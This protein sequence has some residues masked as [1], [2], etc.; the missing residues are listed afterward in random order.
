MW[1]MRP[2]S[3]SRA[4]A[5]TAR[6]SR[7]VGPGPGDAGEVDRRVVVH[8]RQQH[9]LGEAAGLVLQRGQRAQVAD[10]V[11]RGV[12]VAVHHRRGR[13]GCRRVC[14]VLMISS[15]VA[16]GSLPLVS[17]Q[18]TSSSRISAAVPGIESSPA[19]FAAV[20][21]V[22]E[23]QPGAGGAVDD[24]HRAERVQ[25]DAG[26]PLP[27]PRG[28]GRSRPCRAGRGGC[29][30][31]CRSRS[32]RRPRPRRPGRRPAPSTACRRRR[33]CAAGRTRRTG[34]RCSRRW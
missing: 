15:Q 7:T 19:S 34:S 30:P 10:P 25:V 5:C 24:L 6:F 8:E 29:R 4:T 12:D 28:R 13:S 9:E 14:A 22:G 31:A 32:R 17:T 3:S 27:S 23:R 2:C 1:S 26:L 18:R 11:R 33:R 20:Q 16:V 21:E